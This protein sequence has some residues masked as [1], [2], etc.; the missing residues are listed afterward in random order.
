MFQTYVTLG[1]EVAVEEDKAI[2]RWLRHDFSS[3][4]ILDNSMARRAKT[5]YATS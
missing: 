5:T 4:Y 1:F 2:M 3:R